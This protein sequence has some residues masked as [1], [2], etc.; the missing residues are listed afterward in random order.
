LLAR[1][2]EMMRM[3]SSWRTRVNDG[4]QY[5]GLGVADEGIAGFVVVSGVHYP[6]EWIEKSLARRLERD[7]VFRVVGFSFN[8]IPFKTGAAIGEL[9]GPG[10]SVL[11]LAIR[12]K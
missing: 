11:T 10:H 9:D 7:P 1:R 4:Q 2:A 12:H 5:L 3:I 8:V 6:S